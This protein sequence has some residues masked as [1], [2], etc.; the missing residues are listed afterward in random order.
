[1][2]GQHVHAGELLGTLEAMKMELAI[3]APL[4]GV[5]TEIGFAVGDRVALGETLFLVDVLEDSE[6]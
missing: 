5:V 3:K 2:A 4:D 1:V 6:S